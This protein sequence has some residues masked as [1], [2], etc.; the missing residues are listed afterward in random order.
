MQDW[1]IVETAADIIEKR[2]YC[3]GSLVDEQ[4]RVCVDGA[5]A[6]ALGLPEI[7]DVEDLVTRSAGRAPADFGLY[8][9]PQLNEICGRIAD[10]LELED[11]TCGNTTRLWRWNDKSVYYQID[12]TEEEDKQ[13]IL[14]GLRKAAKMI[15]QQDEA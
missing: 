11:S 5:L 12:V 3:R 2:G 14:D 4:R 7:N 13:R 10:A 1:E 8:K 15:R 6:F 9:H